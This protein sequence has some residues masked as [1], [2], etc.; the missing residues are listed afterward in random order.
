[1][2][3]CKSSAVILVCAFITAVALNGC[4]QSNS[5]GTKITSFSQV[6]VGT[7]KCTNSIIINGYTVTGYGTLI[8][9][10]DTSATETSVVDHTSII[11]DFA[12]QSGRTPDEEWALIKSMDTSNTIYSVGSPYISTSTHVYTDSDIQGITVTLSGNTLIF[13]GSGGAASCVTYIKQ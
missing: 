2:K 6:P 3:S 4:V 9:T 1:M 13:T 11:N 5:S 8:T 10:G 7:W 12:K